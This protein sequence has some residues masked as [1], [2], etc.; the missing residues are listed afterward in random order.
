MPIG[1]SVD[2]YWPQCVCLLAPVCTPIGPSVDP[3]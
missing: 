2:A 1:P 3:Y